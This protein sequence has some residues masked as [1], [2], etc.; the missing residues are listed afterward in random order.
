MKMKVLNGGIN[1]INRTRPIIFIEYL[2]TG[3][4]NIANF[5]QPLGYCLFEVGSINL[6]CIHQTDILLQQLQTNR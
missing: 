1:T 4:E 6:L 3:K 2:K 5:L